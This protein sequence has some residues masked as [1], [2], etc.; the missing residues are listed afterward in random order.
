MRLA[1][2]ALT[3]AL[4]FAL[5]LAGCFADTPDSVAT[6]VDALRLPV[7]GGQDIPVW[8]DGRELAKGDAFSWTID[9]KDVVTV[10]LMGDRTGVH[11][12]AMAPGHATITLGYR[13]TATT[14]P[15]DIVE[16]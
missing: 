13:T 3:F 12:T 6:E 10:E 15:V 11:V 7:G 9:H 8:V 14:L 1:A 4:T 16:P 2:P 5:A